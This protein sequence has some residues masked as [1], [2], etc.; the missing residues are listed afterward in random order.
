MEVDECL[1]ADTDL[2]VTD[3]SASVE[4]GPN[5]DCDSHHAASSVT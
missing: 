1:Q 3:A 5:R 4:Q 2:H